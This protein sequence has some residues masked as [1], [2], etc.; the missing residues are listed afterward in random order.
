MVKY[1]VPKPEFKKLRFVRLQ[2][3]VV[4]TILFDEIVFKFSIQ[5]KCK[6]NYIY[7][8]DSESPVESLN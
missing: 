1:L 2:S 5:Y 7:C 6:E 3:P 8:I 4:L